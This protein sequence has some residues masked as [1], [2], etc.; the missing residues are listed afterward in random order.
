MAMVYSKQVKSATVAVAMCAQTNVAIGIRANLVQ[1]RN[2][3][4]APVATLNRAR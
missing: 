1:M 3:P 2:A 4:V